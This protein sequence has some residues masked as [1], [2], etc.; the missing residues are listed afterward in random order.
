MV[1]YRIN[2]EDVFTISVT[3][4]ITSAM[5]TR[6]RESVG[7]KIKGPTVE[8]ALVTKLHSNAPNEPHIAIGSHERSEQTA[9]S[10]MCGTSMH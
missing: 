7:L 10:D 2:Q 1:I 3:S 6:H 9:A 8:F 5:R 4:T